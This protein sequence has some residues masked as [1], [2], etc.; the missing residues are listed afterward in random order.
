[1]QRLSHSRSNKVIS[2][3]CLILD[4]TKYFQ[5]VNR[6]E[7]PLLQITLSITIT[8]HVSLLFRGPCIAEVAQSQ[9][10]LLYCRCVISCLCRSMSDCSYFL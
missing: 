7:R 6:L 2:S 1:M 4:A 3:S 9:Q 10:R 8:P 5:C